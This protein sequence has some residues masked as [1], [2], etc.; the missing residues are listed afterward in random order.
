MTYHEE[1]QYAQRADTEHISRRPGTLLVGAEYDKTELSSHHI[2]RLETSA[3]A[4][5]K[6]TADEKIILIPQP[7]D[8][9]RQPLNVNL[10]D[11]L[12]ADE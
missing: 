5:L 11:L 7:T 12:L 10:S 1:R 8:D 2:E 9:P 6:K 4:R 3:I